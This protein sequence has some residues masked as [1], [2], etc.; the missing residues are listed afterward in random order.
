MQKLRKTVR[1]RTDKRQTVEEPDEVESLMSGFEAEWRGRPR[2]LGSE[3]LGDTGDPTPPSS[4][5]I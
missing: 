2:R 3:L 4:V 5:W 1:V